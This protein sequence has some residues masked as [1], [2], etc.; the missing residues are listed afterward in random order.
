MQNTAEKISGTQAHVQMPACV[1]LFS[2][3]ASEETELK[4]LLNNSFTSAD[5]MLMKL[6][7]LCEPE[8]SSDQIG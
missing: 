6:F 4:R 3:A 5:F 2:K 7:L 8:K 1:E